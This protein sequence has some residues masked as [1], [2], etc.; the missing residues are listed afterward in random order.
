MRN[1]RSAAVALN[2]LP[3]SRHTCLQ[4]PAY[5][6]LGGKT[7]NAASVPGRLCVHTSVCTRWRLALF[8]T[9]LGRCE[10]FSAAHKSCAQK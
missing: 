3:S 7:V 9:P 8:S 4:H 6:E 1:R 2:L 10:H 5:L